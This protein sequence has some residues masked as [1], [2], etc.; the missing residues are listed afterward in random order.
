[1]GGALTWAASWGHARATIRRPDGSTATVSGNGDSI[2][3]ANGTAV[4]GA[5][6]PAALSAHEAAGEWDGTEYVNWL[7]FGVAARRRLMVTPGGAMTSLVVSGNAR[8]RVNAYDGSLALEQMVPLG[9]R[10]SALFRLGGGYGVREYNINLPHDLESTLADGPFGTT[11][12][13][14][15]LRMDARIEPLLGV[16]L[17]AN[18]LSLTFQPYFT[19]AHGNVRDARCV[20]CLTGVDLLDYTQSWGFAVAVTVNTR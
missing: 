18:V 17:G 20:D 19:V 8:W 2:Y 14:N 3:G 9:E 15:L 13:W 6:P 12:H 1:M 5:T 11:G 10:T 16:V 4:I 7:R